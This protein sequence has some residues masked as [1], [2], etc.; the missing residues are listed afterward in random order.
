V[1]SGGLGTSNTQQAAIPAILG[2]QPNDRALSIFDRTHR[3]TF[4]YVIQSPF[5]KDQQGFVG[6]LLGGFQLS[7]VT[8][9]ESGVPFT[10]SNGFDSDGVGGSLDRPTFNPNGQRG[11][12]AIPRVNA[13]GFITGY[14]NPEVI[15]GQT[16]TGAPIFAPIDPNTAQF[17][18]NP[19]YVAG[20]PGSVVRVGNLGRNTE[21]SKGIRNFDMTLL[22]RTRISE[23]VFIEGRIE[24]FNVFNHP[25]FGSGDSI[26][27]AETQGLFLQ[28]INPTTS[29]GGRV[30]RYQAKIRF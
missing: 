17:I 4:T 13:Q 18:V 19:A 15:I 21:R 8:T 12:R 16:S 26:A 20:L 2:G 22:K 25:Q 9:F 14:I 7:G 24:A 28:P 3:A 27:N 11:V 30:L 29:G 6:R 23:N 1:F 10:V 5:F